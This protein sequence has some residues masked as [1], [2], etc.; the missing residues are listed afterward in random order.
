MPIRLP[1]TSRLRELALREGFRSGLEMKAAAQL[2]A[3]GIPVA[4]ET[5][6]VEY[7]VPATPKKY[8][9]DFR[10]PNGTLIETKGYFDS[11]DR[12]KHKHIKAQHPDLPLVIVFSNPN[13]RLGKKSKTTY[14]Q[15]CDTHGI[16]WMKAHS[17]EQPLPPELLK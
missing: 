10:L 12:T 8:K 4:Y 15:W 3:A 13:N 6:T 17:R 14:A 9:V 5:H 7:I 16:K 11:A 2:H 1:T